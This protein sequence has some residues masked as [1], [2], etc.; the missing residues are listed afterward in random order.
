MVRHRSWAVLSLAWLPLVTACGPAIGGNAVTRGHGDAS[1]A[2]S[3][4]AEAGS[5]AGAGGSPGNDAGSGDAPSSG[6][7]TSTGGFTA[8]PCSPYANDAPA[9]VRTSQGGPPPAP[10][11]GTIVDGK[12]WLTSENYPAT[13]GTSVS[14]TERIDISRGGTYFDDV[15]A[16][17]GGSETR[18]GTSITTTGTAATLT[19]VC[20][21]YKGAVAQVHYS[22]TPTRLV[23]I[24]QSGGWKAYSRQ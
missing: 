7:A 13:A 19:I 5:Q 9:I 22:A 23:I 6:G 24:L 10:T 20:G 18:S 1:N 2:P 21:A 3:D 14:V 17:Q 4:S 11:G 8:G 16:L 12:Y 15:T